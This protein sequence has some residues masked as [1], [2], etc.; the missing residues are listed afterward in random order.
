M[1]LS[2]SSFAVTDSDIASNIG[3]V[4]L[5]HTSLKQD[6]NGIPQLLLTQSVSRKTTRFLKEEINRERPDGGDYSF[7]SGH[8]ARAFSAAWYIHNRYGIKE[9]WP[10][11]AAS[12]WVA[13]RRVDKKRHY[14]SD[15]VGSAVLTYGVSRVFTSKPDEGPII[16]IWYQDGVQ[17]SFITKF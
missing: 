8:T 3:K 4:A 5:V 13:E 6:W 14:V 10:Y 9:S 15:V 11:L 7:P 12:V 2:L 16:G 1:G 17:L